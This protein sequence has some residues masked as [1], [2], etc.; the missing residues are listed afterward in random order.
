M[1]ETSDT[2]QLWQ[3]TSDEDQTRDV[4][5]IQLG[6][7]NQRK[8]NIPII[9]FR[10]AIYHIRVIC[11]ICVEADPNRSQAPRFETQAARHQN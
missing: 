11:F 10:I 3:G 7:A 6:K 5:R 8:K 9:R 2:F 1:S 4:Y